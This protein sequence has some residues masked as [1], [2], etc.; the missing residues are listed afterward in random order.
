MLSCGGICVAN[1]FEK[2][3][4]FKTKA[5]YVKFLNYENCF[6]DCFI[7]LMLM[8]IQR[9]STALSAMIIKF[10]YSKDKLEF[11]ATERQT[12]NLIKFV[13][14]YLINNNNTRKHIKTLIFRRR[15]EK[16]FPI[17]LTRTLKRDFLHDASKLHEGNVCLRGELLKLGKIL[18]IKKMSLMILV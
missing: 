4:N 12:I 2:L 6:A 10:M 16:S 3:K 9:V 7:Q 1:K 14:S 13:K 15:E 18:C 17:N 8:L 5:T 11:S